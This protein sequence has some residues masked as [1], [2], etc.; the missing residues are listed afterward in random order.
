MQQMLRSRVRQSGK[1]P[2]EEPQTG[3]PSLKPK[4]VPQTGES[5]D[6]VAFNQE[7]ETGRSGRASTDAVQVNRR[8]VVGKPGRHL[9]DTPQI[10]RTGGTGRQ[11]HG[12]GQVRAEEARRPVRQS[13]GTVEV[14]QE[15]TRRPGRQ[16]HGAVEVRGEE[17][18]RPGRQSHGAVEGRAEEAHRPGRQSHGAVQIRKEEVRQPGRTPQN[19][20]QISNTMECSQLWVRVIDIEKMQ[21]LT[22]FNKNKPQPNAAQ[23]NTTQIDQQMDIS[24]SNGD[25]SVQSNKRRAVMSQQENPKKVRGMVNPIDANNCQLMDSNKEVVRDC[26]I[27]EKNKENDEIDDALAA[28]VYACNLPFDVIESSYFKKFVGKLNRNYAKKIPSKRKLSATK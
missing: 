28:F 17:A 23:A 10:N 18:R 11:S 2:K 15:Q 13:H 26:A 12:A 19:A 5:A 1:A 16:S 3:E 8:V 21:S 22:V 9:Y 14:R 25:L 24:F 27:V 7:L 6:A 20:I 4:E